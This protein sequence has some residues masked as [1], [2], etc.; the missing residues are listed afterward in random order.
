MPTSEAQKRANEK[1]R[2]TE[3]G[4]EVVKK[5]SDEYGKNGRVQVQFNV[6]VKSESDIIAA[7]EKLSVPKGQYAKTA[8][9]D[10]LVRDGYLK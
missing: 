4:K 2:Q 8:F 5:Y 1:Y 3:K 6:A 10:A 9:I 7:I